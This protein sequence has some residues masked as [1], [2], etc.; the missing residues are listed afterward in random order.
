MKIVK[1]KKFS[2]S[3]DNI[4]D[5]IV[6]DGISTAKKF[7]RKLQLSLQGIQCSPINQEDLFTMIMNTPETMCLR[8]I[9]YPI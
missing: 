1:D 2:S 4:L 7:N 6:Q 5:Y 3:L 8:V 9:L